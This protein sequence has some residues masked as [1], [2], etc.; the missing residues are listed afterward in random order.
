MQCAEGCLYELKLRQFRPAIL[1]GFD[2]YFRV[3][4]IRLRTF[5]KRVGFD[6]KGLAIHVYFIPTGISAVFNKSSAVYN[7]DFTVDTGISNI[8]AISSNLNP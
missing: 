1:T 5:P 6:V 7:R 2:V 4:A 3:A 8:S